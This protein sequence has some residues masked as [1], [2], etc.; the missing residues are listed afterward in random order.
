MIR[1]K[2][3]LKPKKEEYKVSWKEDMEF[4]KEI[5]NLSLPLIDQIVTYYTSDEKIFNITIQPYYTH[6]QNTRYTM[7]TLVN[8]IMKILYHL[9]GDKN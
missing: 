3:R 7:D 1:D 2:L 9:V 5:V 8:S 4:N 6:V